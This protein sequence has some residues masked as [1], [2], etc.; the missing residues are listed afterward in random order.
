[1]KRSLIVAA[2]ILALA[3]VVGGWNQLRLNAARRDHDA[4]FAAAERA[5]VSPSSPRTKTS[6][7]VRDEDKVRSALAE[8]LAAAGSGGNLARMIPIIGYQLT[9]SGRKELAIAIGEDQTMTYAQR[10]EILLHLLQSCTFSGEPETILQL[11]TSRPE[12]FTANDSE[13]Q[14][15]HA[16]QV[17][18]EN[19][20]ESALKWALEIH[21]KAPRLMPSFTDLLNRHVSKLPPDRMFEWFRAMEQIPP[22]LTWSRYFAAGQTAAQQQE[23]FTTLR[24][25][26][27]TLKS[28]A[29]QERVM[30]EALSQFGGQ[31]AS[32][33]FQIGSATADRTLLTAGEANQAITSSLLDENALAKGET[34]LWIE[35]TLG[36]FPGETKSL[37]VRRIVTLWASKDYPAAGKWLASF[38]DGPGKTEAVMGYIRSVAKLEPDV[39]RQW[40]MTLP[41]KE[42]EIELT[43]IQKAND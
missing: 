20:V 10:S 33:G 22:I 27:E 31:I 13:I 16:L 35:W 28:P 21:Q 17:V 12:F 14:V 36:K 30:R 11:V 38:P 8:C 24:Q 3:S 43:R 18:A 41:S 15:M 7:R 5:G 26:V 29:D 37:D 2:S 32:A 23:R 4:A 19:D 40:A 39:A 6:V 1:M 9:T 25:Y 34:G 42:R